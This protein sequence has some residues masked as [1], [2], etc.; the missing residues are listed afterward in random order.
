MAKMIIIGLLVVF[1]CIFYTYK[2]INNLLKYTKIKYRK[3][4]SILFSIALSI[5]AIQIF[6]LY[7]LIYLYLLFFLIISDIVIYLFHKESLKNRIL[8]IISSIVIVSV[9]LT[10]GYYNMEHVVVTTYHLKSNKVKHLD[11]LAISDL[12]MGNTMNRNK[13]MQE[14]QKLNNRIHPDYVFLVGDIVDERTNKELMKDTFKILSTI[15]HKYG[16]YYVYGNHDDNQYIKVPHF[17]HSDIKKE[18][19][20]NKIQVLE[21]EVVNLNKI[22]I[23]GR[24]DVSDKSRF[25]IEKLIK[26]ATNSYK[27]VLDHQPVDYKNTSKYVDMQISGHTHGG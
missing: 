18:A 12:H 7:A 26:Q 27:L 5:P 2:V 23:I 16:I 21:D 13:L 17:T 15:N 6:G 22:S 20:K 14:I 24:K 1:G 11:I 4:I 8:S 25:N 9:L 10:Y 19:N 3:C